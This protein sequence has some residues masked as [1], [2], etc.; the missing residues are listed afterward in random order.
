MTVWILYVSARLGFV[1][2]VKFP[3][4]ETEG[5]SVANVMRSAQRK[6]I[7]WLKRNGNGIEFVLELLCWEAER[8]R[9]EVGD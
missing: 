1:S 8:D 5:V 7:A 2:R 9:E 6:R 4:F 3:A